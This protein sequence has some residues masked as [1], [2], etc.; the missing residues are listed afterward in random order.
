MEHMFSI[1]HLFDAMIN[2]VPSLPLDQ[3]KMLY[4]LQER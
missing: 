1:I 3:F 4:R 2:P